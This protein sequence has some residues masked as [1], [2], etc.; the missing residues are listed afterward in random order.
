MKLRI[1]VVVLVA[2]L[3]AG[4]RADQ[5]VQ[6]VQQAL[7]DQGFYYGEV[8]GE[9]DADTTAAI[10]R[11]QIR[12]GLQISGDLNDETLKSLGVDSSG[13]RAVVKASPTPPPAAPAT[14]DLRAEPPEKS[15]PTNPLTGQPFP[16][17][18]QDRSVDG[19]IR[20]GEQVP[21]RPNSET[22]PAG[23]AENFAGT[24]YEAAPPQVQRDVILS[25]QNILARRGLYRGA[26]DGSVS[27]DLEFSLRAYQSRAG[28]PVTGR[29]D[30]ETLAA[31]ELLPGA[32]RP[33]YM[34]R[35][36]PV[37]EEPVRGEWIPEP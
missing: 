30:L 22:A 23:P 4:A 13:A 16:E 9:K 35:R 3:A 27:P 26:Y 19:Q 11:Y 12:N 32:N 33:I 24:P 8:T 31:L 1:A 25:A 29:L 28:L 5:V 6:N 21:V 2:A 34:P 15:T 14:S 7:K 20:D 37:R 10:R 18:R 17:P 36:R